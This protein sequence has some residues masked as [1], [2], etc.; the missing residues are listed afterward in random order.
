MGDIPRRLQHFRL[1]PHC[2]LPRP[3]GA[4]HCE[5]CDVCH[6]RA[7]HHCP[8]AGQCVTDRNFK[9]FALSFLWG[10]VSTFLMFW[11]TLIVI[12]LDG[13]AVI[14]IMNGAYSISMAIVLLIA[15]ISFLWQNYRDTQMLFRFNTK[16]LTWR[17]YF[18]ALGKTCW[19]K[20]MPFHAGG[21]SLGWP[22]VDWT[23][24]DLALL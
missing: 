7:D 2:H 1:C 20:V 16:S 19:D 11:P 13:F 23:S 22:G 5:I 10:S 8:V 3:P 9:F 12:L 18:G 24:D 4:I 14:P 6:L 21:T 15:G 17:K